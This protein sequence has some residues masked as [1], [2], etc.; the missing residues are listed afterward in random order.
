MNNIAFSNQSYIACAL[1]NI[2]PLDQFEIR[3][4]L[5]LDASI[6]NIHLALT[7]IGFYLTVGAL[8]V[9][10]LNVLATNYNRVISNR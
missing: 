1:E 10:T 7:N 8:I 2:S 3:D 4:L 6:F 9:L 5:S